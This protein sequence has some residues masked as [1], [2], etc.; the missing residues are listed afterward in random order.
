MT[1]ALSV[2]QEPAI[3]IASWYS[4]CGSWMPTLD[5]VRAGAFSLPPPPLSSSF[6]PVEPAEDTSF[7]VPSSSRAVA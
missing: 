3:V 2:I 7:L 5:A 6:P 4:G 1:Y